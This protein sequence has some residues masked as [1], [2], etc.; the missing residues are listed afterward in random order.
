MFEF[1]E[2]LALV[3]LLAA[4]VLLPASILLAW[5]YMH[6]PPSLAEW[7]KILRFGLPVPARDFATAVTS[8][9]SAI[10]PA[11]AFVSTSAVVTM[12]QIPKAQMHLQFS[13]PSTTSTTGTIGIA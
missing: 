6:E 4:I 8:A 12:S 13:I 1:V 11:S 7:L 10:T 2:A 9:I 5:M 3:M